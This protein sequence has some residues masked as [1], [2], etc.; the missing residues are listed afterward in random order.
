MKTKMKK[1]ITLIILIFVANIFI[2]CSPKK[3]RSE[4]KYVIVFSGGSGYD[5]TNNIRKDI[6]S[7]HY[8]NQDGNSCEA[9]YHNI[10]K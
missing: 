5:F 10:K 8:I 9:F 6:V 1:V 3:S 2:S 4:Y 7:I